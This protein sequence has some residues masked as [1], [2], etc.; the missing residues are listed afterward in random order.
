MARR[1]L[2]TVSLIANLHHFLDEH[3]T[4]PEGIQGLARNLAL[5]LG[6]IAAWVTIRHVGQYELTNVPCRR[7]PGR[8]RRC[9]GTIYARL[10]A[11]GAMIT[12]EC[13]VCGDN[14]TING[15]EGTLW[16]RR[17]RGHM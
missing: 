7:S 13:P 9:S 12:W 4:I 5:F 14:G 1:N 11:D 10:E 15:W 8:R 2:N 6:A 17:S 16:D 3:G